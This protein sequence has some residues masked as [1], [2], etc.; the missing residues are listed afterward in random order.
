M[1]K[2]K[3][4]KDTKA[5]SEMETRRKEAFENYPCAGDVAGGSMLA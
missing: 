4:Q 1:G 5:V 2:P 3:R